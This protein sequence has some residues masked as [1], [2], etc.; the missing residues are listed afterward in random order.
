M[1]RQYLELGKIVGT[2]G[3]HGEVR[4]QPWC[5]SPSFFQQFHTLYFSGSGEKPVRVLASRP[6]GNVVLVRLEGVDTLEAAAALRGRILFMN[7]EEAKLAPGDYF[8]QDLIGCRVIDADTGRFYGALTDVSATGANDVWHVT[9][10]GGVERLLPAIP[11]I[12]IDT[13]VDREEI[14]IRPIRGIF[15]DAEEIRE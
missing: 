14:S 1:R 6:H 9:D 7:R 13:D 15:D 8:I 2:H 5:D 11:S 12:V 4:V 10:P 3:V